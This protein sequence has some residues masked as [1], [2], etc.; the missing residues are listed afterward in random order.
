MFIRVFVNFVSWSH[1]HAMLC[2]AMSCYAE[3]CDEQHS[4]LWLAEEEQ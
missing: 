2:Y 3:N 4:C 1:T